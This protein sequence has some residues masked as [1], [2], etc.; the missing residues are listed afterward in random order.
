[1][2]VADL[3]PPLTVRSMAAILESRRVGIKP[4]GSKPQAQA[5][6]ISYPWS[7]FKY[8]EAIGS[9]MARGAR[10]RQ[11]QIPPAP[12]SS[13][14]YDSIE[15]MASVLLNQ[16][17]EESP[18]GPYVLAGHSFAGLL[19]FELAHQLQARGKTV[20]RLILIDSYIH[21]TRVLPNRLWTRLK[22]I[23]FLMQTD[24]RWLWDRIRVGRREDATTDDAP[25]ARQI[26]QRCDKAMERY[27][28]GTYS[29]D[30]IFIYCEKYDD[31]L[32]HP[33][34]SLNRIIYPWSQLIKGK[35]TSHT[36]NCDHYGVVR[37]K[38]EYSLVAHLIS[39]WAPDR[40][41]SGSSRASEGGNRF[42]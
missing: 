35:L 11:I 17:L 3:D 40:N 15:S 23:G 10:F 4:R 31:A 39:T 1:L 37:V 42:T 22:R 18:T 36:V 26:W 6:L 25:F 16:I 28:P 19:A 34:Y 30:T 27:V 2:S 24:P 9:A 8:P 41:G 14:L 7:M 32:K 33:N 29:G 12:G 20:A 5:F 21:R 13:P 38:E